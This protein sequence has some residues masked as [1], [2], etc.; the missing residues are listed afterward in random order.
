MRDSARPQGLERWGTGIFRF[1]PLTYLDHPDRRCHF[2][3][4]LTGRLSERITR[5][6]SLPIFI[7]EKDS[8]AGSASEV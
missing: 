5:F 6:L 7:R 3:A 1:I 2:G 4:A 8:T